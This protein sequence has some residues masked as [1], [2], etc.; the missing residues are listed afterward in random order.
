[1]AGLT[2]AGVG[3]RRAPG[4]V[5]QLAELTAEAL[6]LKGWTLRSGHA[7]GAD[8]AF[9]RGAG[10]KA[11]VYLPWP[12]FEYG[13][14]LE[15]DLIVDRPHPRAYELAA[16]HHP[17]C[18]RLS[19]GARALHARNM[20]QILGRRLD[21][22]CRFVLCWTP[23]AAETGGT[24]QAMRAARACGMPVYNLAV[25]GVRARAEGLVDAY[26][27]VEGA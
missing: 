17:A 18:D 13:E 4:D 12:T 11:E 8:Q 25:E 10:R 16:E 6:A 26:V 9:E 15:A 1:M 2:Y 3:S 22:P 14:P 27:A 19:R 5:L 20:H 23:G 7:P 21:D 24:G